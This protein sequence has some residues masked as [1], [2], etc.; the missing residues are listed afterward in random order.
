MVAITPGDNHIALWASL[1]GMQ[2]HV[3]SYEFE[4][5]LSLGVQCRN[6]SIFC[7]YKFSNEK[8]S[9]TVLTSTKR[10]LI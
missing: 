8:A 6:A 3:S 1:F 5:D 4:V 9:F 10:N 2:Q 7:T